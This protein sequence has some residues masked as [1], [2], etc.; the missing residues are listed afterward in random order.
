MPQDHD[1]DAKETV[2]RETDDRS[3]GAQQSFLLNLGEAISRLSNS[4]WNLAPQHRSPT[5]T[6]NLSQHRN[7]V[8]SVLPPAP[9]LATPPA[10]VLSQTLPHG[11]LAAAH[12]IQ[13]RRHTCTADDGRSKRVYR[14]ASVTWLYN[15]DLKKQ[16]AVAVGTT[17]G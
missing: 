13:P 9:A 6:G 16:W 14:Q 8:P 3:L 2:Q 7:N 10:H 5:W 1:E 11:Q 4:L 12:T 17:L 15:E